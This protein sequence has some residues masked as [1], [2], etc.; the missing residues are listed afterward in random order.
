MRGKNEHLIETAI[1]EIVN[2][3]PDG[4]AWEYDPTHYPLA[5]VLAAVKQ[6]EDAR[7]RSLKF[8]PVAMRKPQLMAGVS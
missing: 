5:V 7:E 1:A 6:L 4:V 8:K 2:H 3:E